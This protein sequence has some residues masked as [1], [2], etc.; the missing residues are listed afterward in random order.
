MRA[1]SS[2]FVGPRGMV[3]MSAQIFSADIPVFCF[4]ELKLLVKDPGAVWVIYGTGAGNGKLK[5]ALRPKM[6][7]MLTA[8]L[9]IRG[10]HI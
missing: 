7:H 4:K 9:S 10:K 8:K 1:L 5:C 3:T 2:R 6:F